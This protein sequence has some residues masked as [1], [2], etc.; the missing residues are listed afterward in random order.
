MIESTTKGVTTLTEAIDAKRAQDALSAEEMI[1]PKPIPIAEVL[2]PSPGSPLLNVVLS[3]DELG[4][5]AASIQLCVHVHAIAQ[6]SAL[7]VANSVLRK[8]H[9]AKMELVRRDT[10]QDK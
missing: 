8:I 4:C 1:P 7:N 5:I 2:P 3:L 10:N 9:D 6:P